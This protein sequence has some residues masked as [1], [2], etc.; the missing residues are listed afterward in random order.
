M[1]CTA[2]AGRPAVGDALGEAGGDGA[3]GGERFRAALED[4]G[5]ARLE[6]QPGGV[7]GDVGTRLVDHADDAERDRAPGDLEAVRA[8]P[9]WRSSRRPDRAGRRS[10]RDPAAIA[11]TR[12]GLSVKRS[13]R[14]A[15]RPACAGGADIARVG[16]RVS[17]PVR[18]RRRVA[19]AR[20]AAFFAAGSAVASARAAW[21]AARQSAT[22]LSAMS[23]IGSIYR[24]VGGG[25]IEHRKEDS[26]H[27][28]TEITFA[29]RLLPFVFCLARPGSGSVS[30]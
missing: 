20:S 28:G 7:G 14:A 19:A 15:L 27:G 25:S 2:A 8:A 12:A 18:S 21:R 6:A 30:P 3:V 24:R 5:V 23:V 9:A 4:D 17:A 16:R 11:S 13:T 22:T 10:R 1:S 26:Q 29:F